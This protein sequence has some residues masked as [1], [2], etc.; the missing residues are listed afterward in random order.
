MVN[1]TSHFLPS[2]WINGLLREVS[3]LH[4]RNSV[5][6]DGTSGSKLNVPSGFSVNN[7]PDP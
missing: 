3:R 4:E 1:L 2:K 6:I 7:L 5:D